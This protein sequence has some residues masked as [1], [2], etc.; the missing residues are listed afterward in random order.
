MAFDFAKTLSNN[1]IYICDICGSY[2]SLKSSYLKHM[3]SHY[4]CLSEL[5]IQIIQFNTIASG[6][7]N[8]NEILDTNFELGSLLL[9]NEP[10]KKDIFGKYD[11]GRMLVTCPQVKAEN[12]TTGIFA[13]RQKEMS[14]KIEENAESKQATKENLNKENSKQSCHNRENCRSQNKKVSQQ[15]KQQIVKRKNTTPVETCSAVDCKR[16]RSQKNKTATT[17]SKEQ[18]PVLSLHRQAVVRS[19][20]RSTCKS[21]VCWMVFLSYLSNSYYSLV[22]FWGFEQLGGSHK[23]P[24]CYKGVVAGVR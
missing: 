11:K 4:D 20:P 21:K 14:I 17:T 19:S 22:P 8:L 1:P 13:H 24:V 12:D 6:Y 2:F 23:F 15:Q 18:L 16:K 9:D 3:P 5:D 7:T 10:N